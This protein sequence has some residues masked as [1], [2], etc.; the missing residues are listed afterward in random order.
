MASAVLRRAVLQILL[1][2]L[3]LG[4]QALIMQIQWTP[5]RVPLGQLRPHLDADHAAVD[6]SR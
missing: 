1:A 2:V 3:G 6:R 5:A 4:S